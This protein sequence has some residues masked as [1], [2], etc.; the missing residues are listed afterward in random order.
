[1]LLVTLKHESDISLSVIA[2]GQG[3]DKNLNYALTKS[4][5]MGYS[6]VSGCIHVCSYVAI[7]V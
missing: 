1:M 2:R 3:E 5:V 4:K 6:Y 7:C